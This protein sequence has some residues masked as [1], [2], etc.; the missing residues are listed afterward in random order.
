ML[1][2]ANK[3]PAANCQ[4]NPSFV[5]IASG[6][7][8]A[9]TQYWYVGFDPALAVSVRFRKL[10]FCAYCLSDHHRWIPG[11]IVLR[12]T[13]TVI[14]NHSRAQMPARCKLWFE[15]ASLLASVLMTCSQHPRSHQRQFRPE[16][17]ELFFVPRRELKRE[18]S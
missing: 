7:D 1:S 14:D 9:I 15:C 8:G 18:N 2:G 4:A 12:E 10:G 13:E 5:P 11:T 16:V 6:G 3:D 17:S